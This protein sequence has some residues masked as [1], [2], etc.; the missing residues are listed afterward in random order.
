MVLCTFANSLPGLGLKTSTVM[1]VT[2][3]ESEFNP[4]PLDQPA[5]GS[6]CVPDPVQRNL[7]AP[8]VPDHNEV[9]FT[10]FMA[11]L[12]LQQ[13]RLQRGHGCS[14]SSQGPRAR[15]IF[16]ASP[17]ASSNFW[18]GL[19]WTQL[20]P[21]CPALPHQQPGGGGKGGAEG[22]HSASLPCHFL[23]GS[24]TGPVFQT[25]SNKNKPIKWTWKYIH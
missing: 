6:Q 5:W 2:P 18:F 14:R 25:S 21:S 17:W 4:T 15:D 11:L 20:T 7:P 9:G 23:C 8:S 22:C 10:A 1:T 12:L 16:S 24:L 13:L 3:C 19:K